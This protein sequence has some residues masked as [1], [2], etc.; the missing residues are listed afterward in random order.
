MPE[1]PPL[2][3][4]HLTRVVDGQTL[5]ADVSIEVRAEE[6]FV[7]FGPSG[8]GKSSLLRLL[9]RLDEPTGGTVYRRHRLPHDRPAHAPAAR[10]V[11]AAAAHAH[12]GHGGGE[13]GVGPDAA[14][15]AGG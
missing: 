13:R 2:A 6:V 14:G 3:T 7:V 12:R 11:G 5:V 9:N 10:R 1:A 4:E 8:S 15:R